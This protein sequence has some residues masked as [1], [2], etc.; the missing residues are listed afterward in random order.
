M[1]GETEA[2]QSACNATNWRYYFNNKHN[3]RMS[4]R[5][6]AEFTHIFTLRIFRIFT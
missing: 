2:E 1:G 6:A 3:I 4:S 5:A